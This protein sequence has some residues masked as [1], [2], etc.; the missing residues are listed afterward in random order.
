[1]KQLAARADERW[2]SVPSF[3]DAPDKRQP[4][5]AL[6]LKDPG[7]HVHQQTEPTSKQGVRAAVG[8]QQ[9]VR[10][11]SSGQP[12]RERHAAGATTQQQS[13]PWAPTP[14]SEGDPKS[15]R[16]DAANRR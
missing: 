2:N 4:G 15:W 1:M 10:Q 13:A 5:P 6:K 12:G 8:T 11:S 14:K 7:G 9:E 16:P 3:L